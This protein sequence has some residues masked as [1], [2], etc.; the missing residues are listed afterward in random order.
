M[1]PANHCYSIPSSPRKRLGPENIL[2][3]ISAESGSAS[4][5]TESTDPNVGPEPETAAETQ[6]VRGLTSTGTS[7]NELKS[8]PV[9]ASSR[10]EVIV[11][12]SKGEGTRAGNFEVEDWNGSRPQH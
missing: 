3:R 12:D 11:D 5:N 4:A 6:G 10:A 1:F 8:K 2:S 7:D 9:E